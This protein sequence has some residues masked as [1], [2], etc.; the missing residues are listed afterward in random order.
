LFSLLGFPLQ[1]KNKAFTTH[2][3]YRSKSYNKMSSLLPVMTS[4]ELSVRANDNILKRTHSIEDVE[5]YRSEEISC[6]L[7]D[8]N[9]SKKAKI[10]EL[11]TTTM[12]YNVHTNVLTFQTTRKLI[13]EKH[14]RH[15][16]LKIL[17]IPH[18]N[19]SALIVDT[20]PKLTVEQKHS[21]ILPTQLNAAQI[22]M[23]L[24]MEYTLEGSPAIESNV[25][26]SPFLYSDISQYDD[27]SLIEDSEDD[28]EVSY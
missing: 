7:H 4:E 22:E 26:P 12:Y 1:T 15:E 3:S 16:R 18:N 20:Y 2:P 9:K 10:A 5:L 23:W 6:Q 28:S 13:K 11:E 14:K 19:S 17:P 24:G 21:R 25:T 8:N 27:E